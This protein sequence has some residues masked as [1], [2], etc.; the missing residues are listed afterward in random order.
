MSDRAKT[1]LRRSGEVRRIARSASSVAR[2]CVASRPPRPRPSRRRSSRATAARGAPR[3]RY[4]TPSCGRASVRARPPT[5]AR[6]S[7]TDG[8]HASR[9]R[10]TSRGWT[11][12]RTRSSSS[13]LI[14]YDEIE[15]VTVEVVAPDRSRRSAAPRRWAATSPKTPGHSPRGLHVGPQRAR[16]PGAHRRPRVRPP[17]GQPAREP[18]APGISAVTS[19][20]DGAATGSSPARRTT[21]CSTGHLV[22]AAE[23]LEPPSWESCTRRTTRGSTATAPGAPTCRCGRRASRHLEAMASDLAAPFKRQ[24][25]QHS[26]WVPRRES[27]VIPVKLDHWTFVSAQLS[28]RRGADLDLYLRKADVRRTLAAQRWGRKPRGGRARARAGPLRDRGL[29]LRRQRPRNAAPASS[30]SRP[31]AAR[32]A[33]ES[34]SLPGA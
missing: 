10:P 28:G 11:S 30:T 18:R 5:A 22:L 16:G 29:R 13:W 32:A 23:R 31:A 25:R 2:A 20:G 26:R 4:T 7:S 9:S 12:R 33:L 19:S 15:D 1:E 8:N 3:A 24:A 6:S 17:R 14:H 27:R 34:P 21:R